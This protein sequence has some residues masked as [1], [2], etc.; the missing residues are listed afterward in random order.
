MGAGLFVRL[1][2]TSFGAD[3]VWLTAHRRRPARDCAGGVGG[4][5]GRPV[6]REHRDVGAAV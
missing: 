3:L 2:G 1:P 4:A 6:W 5:Y